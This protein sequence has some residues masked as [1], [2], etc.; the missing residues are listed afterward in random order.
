M[1]T[2][3]RV[4]GL[5]PDENSEG[6]KLESHVPGWNSSGGDARRRSNCVRRAGRK[7]RNSGKDRKW[8]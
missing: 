3:G 6:T 4:N 1:Q 7:G 5:E 8:L 2:V